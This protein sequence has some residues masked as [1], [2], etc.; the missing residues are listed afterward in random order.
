METIKQILMRRDNMIKE[1]AEEL[2][3]EAQ[4]A[5]KR[6]LEDGE[7]ELAENICVEFF[8]LEPDYLDELI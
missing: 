5:L 3:L 4:V 1:E 6:Y 7:I 8:G 2:I